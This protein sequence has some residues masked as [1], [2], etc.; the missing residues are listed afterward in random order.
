MRRYLHLVLALMVLVAA[1]GVACDGAEPSAPGATATPTSAQA[2]AAT[3]TAMA[4]PTPTTAQ[5]PAATPT[6]TAAPMPTAADTPAA[7]PTATAAPMPTATDTPAATAAP[8][9]TMAAADTAPANPQAAIYEALLATIPD[10]P[11]TRNDVYIGDYA[12]VRQIFAAIFPL[13]GPGDDEDAVVAF[14]SLEWLPPLGT[15]TQNVDYPWI[16]G[17]PGFLDQVIYGDSSY[18]KLIAGNLQY[19]AFDVRSIDQSILAG[20]TQPVSGAPGAFRPPG[21]RRG[22]ERLL[23]VHRAQPRGTQGHPL[24]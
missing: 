24:L 2:P 8:T 21:R 10:T 16:L 4:A 22:P 17:T 23:R 20:A 15:E 19:L 9:P 3:P 14:M 18:M 6:A 1:I 13:P 5:A 12:L 11:E 7:T